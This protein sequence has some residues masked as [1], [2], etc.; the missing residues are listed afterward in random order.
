MLNFMVRCLAACLFLSAV[1]ARSTAQTS[2]EVHVDR[3]VTFHIK[4]PNAKGVQLL[5]SGEKAQAMER[6]ESGIWSLSVGPLEPAF[7]PYSFVVD[8][9]AMPDPANSIHKTT[10]Y[11]GGESM[12]HVAG[13]KTL[14]W[15]TTAVAHGVIHRHSYRSQ[16][17][18]DER[19]F[20][21]FTPPGYETGNR[22]YPVLYLLHGV[23][24]DETGWTTAGRA[25]VI[26]DNL[27][28]N[29]QA[30]P[31]L[32]VMPLGYGFS[33]PRQDV[34]KA[35]GAPAV[36][37]TI[38]DAFSTNLL[39]E[40]RPLVERDYRVQR[41]PKSQAIAGCSM[42][43]SQAL[44]IALH[45]PELFGTADAMSGAFIMFG[46]DWDAWLPTLPAHSHAPNLYL[47]C[48]KSD[49]LIQTDRKMA[50]WLKA[51][52]FGGSLTE[53]EGGHTWMVWQKNLSELLPKLFR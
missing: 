27:I 14:P 26:L 42:G 51:K 8:G 44:F 23:I 53:N 4:A 40:I 2:L 7:Y 11:G 29:R 5:L 10:V 37:R 36:Q 32:L 50:D 9:S 38:M 52:G 13:P 31:M 46:S 1:A 22:K 16:S 43:G 41:N 39:E 33:N 18:G 24:E 35:F 21:V 6:N 20:L 48:G 19:E 45:H 25:N 47:T 28:A 17:L 15:E 30:K 49:F 3:T 12:L 34:S